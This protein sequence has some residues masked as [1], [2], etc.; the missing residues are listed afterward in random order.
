MAANLGGTVY[1]A[2][3][4]IWCGPKC[5][6]IY[7]RD[8]TVGEAIVMQLRRTP[9]KVIQ[10]IESTGE[11]LTAQEF[12]NY[13]MALAKNILEMGVDAG[14]IVGVYAKHSLHLGTV[15]LAA[16]L[17]GTPVHGVF[18][19]FEKDTITKLY[20]TTRPKLIF[21]DEE[22]YNKVLYVMETLKLNAKIVLMTGS[23]KGIL[24]IKDL[25]TY[26]KDIGDISSFPCTKLS[27]ADTAAILCS[28]G[29]T[30]TPKG[31]MCS[32]QS[33]LHNLL[34]LTATMD[35]VLM[36]FSTM[37]WASGVM[38][39]VQSL[40]YST[41]R[42]VPD[43]AY[44][45]EYFLELVERYKVT[46]IFA[47]GAQ[48]ADLVLNTDKEK[49][50]SALKSIDTLMAGGAKVPQAIQEQMFEILGDNTKRPGFTIGYGLSEIMGGVSLNGGYPFEFK[51]DS[52]GKLWINREACIV[53][54]NGQRLGPNETG[55]VYVHSPYTW[56]GYY[57][58]PEATD[59]AKHG[60]WI[61]T[62]DVGYFDNEGFLHLIGRAKEMFK[63]KNFQICPQPIEEVLQRIPGVAEVCVFPIPD[64]VAENLAA[65]AIVRTKDVE[66][67]QLTAQMVNE[68][69]EREMDS[70]YHLRGGV[71]FVDALPRTD[72]GK[73]QRLKMSQ[74]IGEIDR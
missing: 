72:T 2:A 45:P 40:L 36:C 8:M 6:E 70:F 73:V 5:K 39:L 1:N 26:R 58:N 55:E 41:L 4:K 54:E 46:H 47:T 32:H 15:M 28:S 25:V 61:R 24:N 34:Y 50:R 43:R 67:N 64:L 18:H 10:I 27:S 57:K 14:D 11:T 52:E 66:G 35:S 19:G 59:Q 63:W 60:K 21:C 37:Y 48:M 22:N 65:C 9:Q 42:I 23:L 44:S 17:C 38:N 16:F 74:I 49:A 7:S 20:E 33:M 68:V 51:P 3:E 31:V 12:L 30:G 69:I 53:G 71:Y 62:G 56:L 29:T 13:S